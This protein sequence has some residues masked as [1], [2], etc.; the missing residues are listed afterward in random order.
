MRIIEIIETQPSIKPHT[1]KSV[2]THPLV[3]RAL[4]GALC[5]F[6]FAA[7]S[8]WATLVTWQLNPTS[9]NGA[10][11]SSS[12]NYT[13]SGYTIT[14]RGYDNS[15]GVGVAHELFFKNAG[16]GEFGL[17]LTNTPNN[18]LQVSGTTPLHFIQLDLR[19]ILSQGFTNG[20]ISVG[21][22]QPGES[23]NLYGSNTLG[24]L[25]TKLN[26]TAF[27]S[28]SDDAFVSVPNFGSFQFV[29][30][31]AASADV[32]PVAFQAN[33]TPVPEAASILPVICLISIA[34]AVEVRRRRRAA[35]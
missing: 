7:S 19:S 10:V 16:A 25:G 12:Q 4:Q 6:V 5:T 24:S 30:V 27:D 1:M 23:F 21:S 2:N 9:A 26:A 32:L 33:V 17:G 18:E 31:V 29:S 14:A 15:G 3:R 11:G 22:V 34:T 13:V 28:T 35:V 20:M 8:A